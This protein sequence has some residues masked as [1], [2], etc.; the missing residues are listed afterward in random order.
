MD[1]ELFGENNGKKPKGDVISDNNRNK[2][3]ENYVRREAKQPE[4]NRTRN[5]GADNFY[6][7]VHMMCKGNKYL[8]GMII[9]DLLNS[10]RCRNKR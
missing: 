1:R 7:N 5:E 8:E 9:G 2:K 10:P 3:S 4:A 6:N